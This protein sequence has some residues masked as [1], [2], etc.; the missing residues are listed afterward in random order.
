M[1]GA[2]GARC[3]GSLGREFCWVLGGS[4]FFNASG[5]FLVEAMCVCVG[6]FNRQGAMRW[7]ARLEGVVCCVFD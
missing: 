5:F 2:Y 4:F 6:C 7:F 1:E 3:V